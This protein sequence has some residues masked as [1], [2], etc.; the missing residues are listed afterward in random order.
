[1]RPFAKTP[2]RSWRFCGKIWTVPHRT[3]TRARPVVSDSVL[4][5]SQFRGIRLRGPPHAASGIAGLPGLLS[6]GRLRGS[7][8]IFG[9][10]SLPNI[11]YSGAA[12]YDYLQT[13]AGPFGYPP[14]ALSRPHLPRHPQLA[15]ASRD[16]VA[17]FVQFENRRL[18]MLADASGDS[19]VRSCV[20]RPGC[21]RRPARAAGEVA[22]GPGLFEETATAAGIKPHS[23]KL[24]SPASSPDTTNSNLGRYM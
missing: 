12:V 18:R 24:R 5:S 9:Y 15:R 6:G 1:M 14:H 21:L 11:V 13:K 4:K 17:T 2:S 19:E 20:L 7:A 16:L 23:F 3:F 10:F 8:S 22:D